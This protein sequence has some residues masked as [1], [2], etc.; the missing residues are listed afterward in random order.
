[1]EQEKL[2]PNHDKISH[3]FTILS[4]ELPRLSNLDTNVVI[5]IL[6][7]LQKDLTDNLRAQQRL[8]T[9]LDER[10]LKIQESLESLDT[11]LGRYERSL[12]RL[13]VVS[14]EEEVLSVSQQ[15]NNIPLLRSSPSAIHH[16]KQRHAYLKDQAEP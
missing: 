14:D 7:N 4:E 5:K 8:T 6:E 1:M 11:R 10:L 9:I 13:P 16:S 12:V 15:D 3:A 2:Q